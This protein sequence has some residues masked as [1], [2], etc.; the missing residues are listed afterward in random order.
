MAETRNDFI[1][2]TSG[3]RIHKKIIRGTTPAINAG[4]SYAHGLDATKIISVNGL[5]TIGDGVT[6]MP[7]GFR[8]STGG[9]QLQVT[10]QTG[11]LNIYLEASQDATGNATNRPFVAVIEYYE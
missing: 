9:T 2:A 7:F 3:E 11:A 5:I 10:M 4:V 6:K 8:Q 1:T